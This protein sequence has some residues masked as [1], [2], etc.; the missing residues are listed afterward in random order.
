MRCLSILGACV[1]T[2]AS[3]PH[4]AHAGDD[5]SEWFIVLPLRFT[6]LQSEA[7]MLSGVKVGRSLAPAFSV[8]LS[9]YH[10]FYLSAFKAK[11]SLDGFSEQPRLFINGAGVEAAY[12]LYTDG[13]LAF[14]AQLFVGWVF[15]DYDLDAHAFTAAK[16]H[17]LAL[18][19]AVAAKYRFAS[20]AI[21]LGLGYRPVLT[22]RAVRYDSDLGAG[23]IPIE[24]GLPDGLTVLLSLEASL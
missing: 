21:S 11:A 16:V 1:L 14:D 10:S 24:R 13:A 9:I 23:T 5:H 12:R 7:T 15:V 3:V 18:E 22:E 19:P 6:Q 17:Y 4:R 2:V 20:K 8:A